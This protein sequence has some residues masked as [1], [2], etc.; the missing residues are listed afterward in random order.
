MKSHGGKK[1]AN[2]RNRYVEQV[3]MG[4]LEPAGPPSACSWTLLGT[5]HRGARGPPGPRGSIDPFLR[6][7]IISDEV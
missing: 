1:K 7:G 6:L 2:E 4:D 5:S 3:V